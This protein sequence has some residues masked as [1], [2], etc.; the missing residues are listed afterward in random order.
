MA[1]IPF[2]ELSHLVACLA[3]GVRV[4]SITLLRVDEAGASG[5][6]DPRDDVRNPFT[7]SVLAIA[8]AVGAVFW[9]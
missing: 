7:A 9:C 1:F 3:L 8:P 6:V 4:R 5:R 2:H